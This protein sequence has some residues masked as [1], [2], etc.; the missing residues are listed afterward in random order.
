MNKNNNQK[1]NANTKNKK[2]KQTATVQTL[3]RTLAST[4]KSKAKSI[5]VRI[6]EK[7]P[8]Y[9]RLLTNPF[10]LA[11]F[12]SRVADPLSQYT[13]SYKIHGEFKVVAPSGTT[14]AAYCIRP[15]PFSSIID[16]QSFSGSPSTSSAAGWT[17]PTTNT[18]FFGATTPTAL[19]AIISS[20]RVVSHGIRI[21]AE[22]P[23]QVLTGRLIV[24]RAPRSRADLSYGILSG[25]ALSY[26]TVSGEAL[27]MGAIPPVVANSPFLLETIGAQEFSMPDLIGTD[28][29]MINKPNSYDAFSFVPITTNYLSSGVNDYQELTNT[30][31]AATIGV[32][33]LIDSCKGWDDFYIYIDGL[34]SAANPVINIEYILHLEGVP[35]LTSSSVITAVPSHPP[36]A[37]SQHMGL[38]SILS[39]VAK[40]AGTMFTSAPTAYANITGGRNLLKDAGAAASMYLGKGTQ[41]ALMR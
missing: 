5:T 6:Q 10:D 33:G 21:R 35:V 38:D 29:T 18:S 37:A 15:N 28:I 32:G 11:A 4:S 26:T 30:A 12:G 34:P 27:V 19:S 13:A 41:R 25:V 17:A 31:S 9:L 7:S 40:S 3:L 36:V 23:Q 20:Y 16:V 2:Q 22:I 14:T 8:S 1:G 24:A 39:T